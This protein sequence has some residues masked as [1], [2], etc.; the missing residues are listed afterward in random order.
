MKL[1]GRAYP[2]RSPAGDNLWIH[3]A[4][5]AAA[6]D[7]IL[8][9]DVSGG[10]E[11]GYWGEVLSTAAKARKLGGLVI[12]GGVR[13]GEQLPDVGFPVFSRPFCIRGTGK[14]FGALGHLN[15]EIRIGDVVI[16]P[17]DLIVGDGDGVV[18]I[19]AVLAA[20]VVQKSLERDRHE[21]VYMERL[22]QG[23]ST[24]DIYDLNR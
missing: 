3:R 2:V 7:D 14:D 15:S 11:F 6:P 8:V 9:V 20:E 12:D 22:R 1:A 10:Y 16:A 18:S 17:G 13:D 4:V 23:E 21:V 5:Y 19:P 24:L